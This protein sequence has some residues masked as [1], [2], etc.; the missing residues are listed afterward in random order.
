VV[1][2]TLESMG[3]DE[4]TQ[5][6]KLWVRVSVVVFP[7]KPNVWLLVKKQEVSLIKPKN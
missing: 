1:T 3:R 7:V 6:Y 2:G 5:S 4:A